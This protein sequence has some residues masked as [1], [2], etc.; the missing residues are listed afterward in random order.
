MNKTAL[1]IVAVIAVFG[2]GLT[3]Y[4]KNERAAATAQRAAA[5]R[6]REAAVQRERAAIRSAL[7]QDHAISVE[8][9]KKL[10]FWDKYWDGSDYVRQICLRMDAIDVSL[11]PQDFQSAYKKHA[12]AWA[13]L[14]RVK[15]SNEGWSGFLKGMLGGKPAAFSASTELDNAGKSV[16]SSWSDVQQCAISHGVAP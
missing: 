15:S 14:S 13:E 1:L 9:A 12:A 2:I 5:Q 6:E 8:A 16:A 10:T 7:D 3:A 4:I 11:C